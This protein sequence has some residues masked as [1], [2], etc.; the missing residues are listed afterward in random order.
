MEII[1]SAQR[2]LVG[3]M[4]IDAVVPDYYA[5]FPKACMGG[6][7]RRP[8]VIE[9]SGKVLPCHAASVIPNLEFENIRARSL[10]WIWSESSSFQKFRGQQWMPEP[11]RSCDH[12]N[13]DFGGLPLSG[14]H[15][16]G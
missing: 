10:E 3:K 16:D 1:A 5:R 8:M 15:V 13:E 9:P 12:R 7:G 11:C 6:W 2:R 4:R 14:F